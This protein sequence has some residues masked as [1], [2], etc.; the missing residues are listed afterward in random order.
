MFAR[1]FLLS[2][3]LSMAT[4]MGIGWLSGVPLEM[5]E[6]AAVGVLAMCFWYMIVESES[7]SDGSGE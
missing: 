7:E 6:G 4:A 2:F 1:D 5:T 3:V